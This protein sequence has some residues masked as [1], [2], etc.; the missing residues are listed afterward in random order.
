MSQLRANNYVVW[1]LV[2]RGLNEILR[3]PGASIPGIL[4]PTIFM[5]GSYSVFGRLGTLPGFSGVDYLD[6][7]MPLG[8]LQAAGFAGAATGVNLARDIESGWFDRLMLSPIPRTVILAGIILSAS[9][10]MLFP[11]TLLLTIGWALGLAWPGALGLLI[12]LLLA[13]AFA[14]AMACWS[15]SLAMKFRS[16][17]AAPLMQSTGFV[18]VQFSTAFA[19]LVLLAPWL[20]HVARVNPVTYMLRGIRQGFLDVVTWH[21][22]WP[23]LLAVSILLLLATTI[24]LRS[25]NRIGQ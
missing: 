25:L 20:Q 23:G 3:V 10:R 17:D 14:A 12:A 16:Q 8:L 13:T 15:A 5:L 7:I 19:P 22:T 6:W 2:K 24:S 1:A 4:A 18:L 21:N 11:A 9:V